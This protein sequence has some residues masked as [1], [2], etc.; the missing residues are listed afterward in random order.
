MGR[1]QR[2]SYLAVVFGWY[3][4]CPILALGHVSS[5]SFCSLVRDSTS[6][7]TLHLSPN[8]LFFI[9]VAFSQR[10]INILSFLLHSSPT[11]A[12]H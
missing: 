8:F 9:F 3:G 5:L 7:G 6:R 4:S 2:A 12:I 11:C 1:G 10:M